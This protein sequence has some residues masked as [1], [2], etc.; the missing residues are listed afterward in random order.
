MLFIHNNGFHYDIYT[1]VLNMFWLYSWIF[2]THST[3]YNLFPFLLFSSSLLFSYLFLFPY[4]R[5]V[6][7][8]FQCS[9]QEHRYLTSS[10]HWRKCLPCQ[11]WTAYE[12]SVEGVLSHAFCGRVLVQAIT[13]AVSLRAETAF[14][15]TA[16]FFHCWHP[17]CP[18]SYSV[19]RALE[20]VIQMSHS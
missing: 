15:I 1:Y 11:P 19:P 20:K 18:F 8:E 2:S 17:S 4:G 6:P 10:S 9:L 13:A 14:R 3:F 16:C 12:S 7:V 5:G